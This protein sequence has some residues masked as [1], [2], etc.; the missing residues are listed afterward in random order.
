MQTCALI[1]AREV[2]E[3]TVPALP[4]PLSTSVSSCRPTS[5]FSPAA[6][7]RPSFAGPPEDTAV[8]GGGDNPQ[9]SGIQ[10]SVSPKCPHVTRETRVET[11]SSHDYVSNN[12]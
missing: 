2:H 8:C 4:P 3:Y 11:C 12:Y 9:G 1:F 6:M 7:N 10:I 5:I